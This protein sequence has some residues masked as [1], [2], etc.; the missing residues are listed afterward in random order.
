MLA[1]IISIFFIKRLQAVKFHSQLKVT[2]KVKRDRHVLY[3]Y[4]IFT[5]T[6][7][8]PLPWCK[9]TRGNFKRTGTIS[10]NVEVLLPF[11]QQ[12]TNDAETHHILYPMWGT[13][14]ITSAQ[15]SE[16]RSWIYLDVR[17]GTGGQVTR[18]RM[19]IE[20]ENMR[21]KKPQTILVSI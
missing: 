12:T 10:I 13:A 2:V 15:R 21:K 7:W 3:K 16:A 11:K 18:T 19:C 14:N 8:P 6:V 17:N 5:I 4:M 20:G 1:D 9:Y